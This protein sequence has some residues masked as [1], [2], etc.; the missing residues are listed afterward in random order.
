MSIFNIAQDKF[1][2]LLGPSLI[3]IV[4]PQSFPHLNS[5][6]QKTHLIDTETGFPNQRPT[7]TLGV[8]PYLWHFWRWKVIVLSSNDVISFATVDGNQKS[9]IN[10][11]VERRLV[12]EIPINLQGFKNIPGGWEMLGMGF[13]NHQQ[14][15][16]GKRLWKNG[17]TKWTNEWKLCVLF[18]VSWS[19][20]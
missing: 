7:A 16:L 10:S 15:C 9:G 20:T 17:C 5:T 13:P 12:V 6:E 3:L 1:P 18:Q 8:E 4:G 14:Y 19:W 2:L 11:P